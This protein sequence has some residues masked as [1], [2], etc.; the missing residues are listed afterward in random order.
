MII[1]DY[2]LA[3]HEEAEAAYFAQIEYIEQQDQMEARGG[4]QYRFT[5]DV[6]DNDEIPF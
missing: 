1:L 2:E 4:P 5:F 3:W 6:Y